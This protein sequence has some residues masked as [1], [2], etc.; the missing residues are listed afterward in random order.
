[1]KIK[2]LLTMMAGRVIFRACIL[3]TSKSY[4]EYSKTPEFA[5]ILIFA[6]DLAVVEV[7][8]GFHASLLCIQ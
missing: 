3:L 1:M 6:D 2:T 4:T 5:G 7:C 8:I